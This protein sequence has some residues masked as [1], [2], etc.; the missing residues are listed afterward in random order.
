MN[1]SIV[2]R[3]KM[4]WCLAMKSLQRET[5]FLSLRLSCSHS[6]SVCCVVSACLAQEQSSGPIHAYW[7]HTAPLQTQQCPY[8]SFRNIWSEVLK[9]ILRLAMLHSTVA[10]WHAA[11]GELENP[12]SAGHCQVKAVAKGWKTAE[13]AQV[14]GC[15]T[16]FSGSPVMLL[17]CFIFPMYSHLNWGN[18]KLQYYC[19]KTLEWLKVST[20]VQFC[21]ALAW[22]AR[23]LVFFGKHIK[24]KSGK[25]TF[26]MVNSL[27]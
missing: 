17:H 18:V 13:Q 9:V 2:R 27:M 21:R 25:I 3:G 20:A 19:C 24:T 14:L 4:E 7:E 26:K 1:L 8:L 15:V 6:S 12:P 22:E 16:R 23:K 10:I 5:G 11:L